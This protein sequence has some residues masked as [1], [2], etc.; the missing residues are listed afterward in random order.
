VEIA[1]LLKVATFGMAR[2]S[3]PQ[4]FPSFDTDNVQAYASLERFDRVEARLVP[5]GH[6]PVWDRR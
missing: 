1:P 3:G 2:E 4:L 6:G 5:S